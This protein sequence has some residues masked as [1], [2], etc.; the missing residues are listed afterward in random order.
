MAQ[1]QRSTDD[2]GFGITYSQP[3]TEVTGKSFSVSSTD[4]AGNDDKA[5]LLLG[6]A[7][8]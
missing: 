6:E 7:S 8:G 4:K 2:R 5:A 3:W 1:C